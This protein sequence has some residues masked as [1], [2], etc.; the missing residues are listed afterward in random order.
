M[1]ENKFK[2][3]NMAKPIEKHTTAAWANIEKTQP[4]SNV[5]MPNDQEIGDAKEYVDKNQK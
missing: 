4:V 2:E 5:T 1:A 3:K